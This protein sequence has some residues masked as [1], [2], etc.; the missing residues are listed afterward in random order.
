[1]ELRAV[2]AD[3]MK[4]LLCNPRVFV[5]RI[6]TTAMYSAVTVC[7][8]MLTADILSVEDPVAAY[9]IGL[10]ALMLLAFMPALYIID[11]L[12][13][14]MYPR[15]VADLRASRR[16]SLSSALRDALAAWRVVL[17]LGLT[18]FFLFLVILVSSTALAYIFA[19]SGNMLILAVSALAIISLVLI[20]AI[21]VFF[22]VPAA[23]LERG[24]VIESF[25][26]SVRLGLKHKA[27]ILKLN[28][29]FMALLS[30]TVVIALEATLEGG[31]TFMSLLPFLLV[32]VLQVVVYTYLSLANPVA[33]IRVT[34]TARPT[35]AQTHLNDKNL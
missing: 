17:A 11:L 3:A 1:M 15:M 19:T 16:V 35:S 6:V 8:V 26:T 5:P 30:A 13:Y 22:L 27:D 29:I 14:A 2:L 32:R 20:F 28:L 4:M 10:K 33:Y 25:R 31:L 23:V 24:G 7:Y 34:V 12:S 18:L 9:S 21:L